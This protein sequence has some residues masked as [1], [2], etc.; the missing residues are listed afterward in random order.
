MKS[1]IVILFSIILVCTSAVC[2]QPVEKIENS[3]TPL[4]AKFMSILKK[5]NSQNYF[6]FGYGIIR[7]GGRS[8]FCGSFCYDQDN[9]PISLRD[10]IDGTK[11]HQRDKSTLSRVKNNCVFGKTIK[12][13]N[14]ISVNND[15]SKETALLFL[16][17]KN[18]KTINDFVELFICDLSDF[19]DLQNYPLFWLGKTENKISFELV[20]NLYK[21]SGK[22]HF[23]EKL[24][25]GIGI[26]ESLRSA[27]A[28]LVEII[29]KEK[30]IELKKK[31][32]LLAGFTEQC[33]CLCGVKEDYL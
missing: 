11:K 9:E 4:S 13:K 19:I 23:K 15:F 30:E 29:N 17:D 33:G 27:T 12:I 3:S 6:W 10:I 20:S 31:C 1:K 26:H 24:L 22:N 5:A 32:G 25:P 28:L 14:G 8:V 21:N 7:N 16:Y 2:G 18:S